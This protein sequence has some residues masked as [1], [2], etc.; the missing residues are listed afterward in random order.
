[1][2]IIQGINTHTIHPSIDHGSHKAKA[3]DDDVQRGKR[4]G[5]HG[6]HKVKARVDDD[7]EEMQGVESPGIYF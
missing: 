6:S 7:D 1:M 3:R 5:I 4:K 2:S